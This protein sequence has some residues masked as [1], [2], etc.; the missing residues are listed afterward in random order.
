MQNNFSE[1]VKNILNKNR[2]PTRSPRQKYKMKAI[3]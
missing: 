3:K 1:F 2:G